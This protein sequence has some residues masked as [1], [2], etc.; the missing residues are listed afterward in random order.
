MGL[1][2]WLLDLLFPPKCVFCWK[3]QD[4]KDALCGHC[5]ASLPYTVDGGKKDD[6]Y[7]QFDFCLSPLYY[8]GDVRNSILRYKFRASVAYADV[9]GKLLADCIRENLHIEYDILSWVPLSRKRKRQRGY[10]QAYLLAVATASE[11]G[12]AVTETLIKSRNVKAQSELPHKEE[13]LKN[14]SGAFELAEH[15]DIMGKTVLL[16]DDIITTGAT[17]SECAGVLLTGG[18]ARVICATLARGE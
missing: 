15:T 9:Y 14:I 8:I 18:A 4:A 3:I 16:I 7:K 11:L 6:D 2:S 5:L 17:L 12:V 1:G 13:R 10:D